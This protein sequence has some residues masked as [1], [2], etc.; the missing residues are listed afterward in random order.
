MHTVLTGLGLHAE[1]SILIALD[2]VHARALCNIETWGMQTADTI[3]LC[4]AEELGEVATEQLA[5]KTHGETSVSDAYAA[6]ARLQYEAVDLA[7]LC[8]QLVALC[9]VVIAPDLTVS[10]VPRSEEPA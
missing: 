5:V 4:M 9:E 7:A 6:V 1:P 3:I 2:K 10:M 8:M